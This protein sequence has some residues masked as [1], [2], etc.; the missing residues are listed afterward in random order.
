MVVIEVSRAKLL[1]A[2]NVGTNT[3]VAFI[4]AKSC[5]MEAP[6][7]RTVVARVDA[8]IPSLNDNIAVHGAVA[9]SGSYRGFTQEGTPAENRRPL[10]TSASA[11]DANNKAAVGTTRLA[12]N[13]VVR[14]LG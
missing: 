6:A 2:S 11:G 12:A 1:S 5:R 8:D 4:R 14:I 10:L 9:W 3:D 7:P 13:N